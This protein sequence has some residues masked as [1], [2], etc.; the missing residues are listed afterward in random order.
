[1][2]LSSGAVLAESL[3]QALISAYQ[4]NPTLLAERAALRAT[5]E[6]V[7]SALSGWRPTV[8]I[9]GDA[10]FAETETTTV[11]GGLTSK[12]ESS[13]QPRSFSFS[14]TE[15]LYRGGRTIAE[16]SSAKNLVDAGRATL[17]LAEQSILLDGVTA[18]MDVLRTQSVVELNRHNERVVARQHQAAQDRFEVGEVTRTDVAQAEA[19]VAQA[20][21]DRISAEG[22]LI[23]ARATYRQVIGDLPGK[24][25]WPAALAGVPASEREA[26]QTANVANPSIIGADYAELSARDDIDVALSDLLPQVS[27]SAGYDRQYDVSSATE[28]ADSLSLSAIVTVPLYQSGAEHASVRRSKQ[29]ASQRRL[30]F[31]EARRAV[32]EE[33][34]R[35]WEALITAQAKIAAFESQVRA[36]ELAL[37]GV[38]Q[39]VLVGLRTTLDVL[40]AEQELFTARVNLVGAERDAVVS[41]YWV[42][43]TVGELTAAALGLPVESY[44]AD[45]HYRAVGGKWFGISAD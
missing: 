39:E 2:A 4:N 31:E 44:D 41:S 38:E 42:K 11:S 29:I 5:D 7:A 43:S 35:A 13:L 40:D 12:T 8:Q 22:D 24:L 23:S 26:L 28:Q 32:L 18:Y 9:D 17:A 19:R 33:V 37:E 14:I 45:A 34:T 10:G 21:A 27:L 16:T 36:A 15:P 30:E 20:K 3:E 25:A 1:M 6:G